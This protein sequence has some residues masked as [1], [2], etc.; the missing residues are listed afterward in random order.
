MTI[1]YIYTFIALFLLYRLPSL[2]SLKLAKALGFSEY[3]FPKDYYLSFEEMVKNAGYKFECHEVTTEDGYILKVFRIM[4][5]STAPKGVV[6][7]Q[8]G[9]MGLADQWIYNYV[10]K[11]PAFVLAKAGYDVWLGNSRG[12]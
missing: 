10:D 9:V 12:N 11:A 2:F 8:H 4:G 5:A 3:K 7:L 6:L 1:I